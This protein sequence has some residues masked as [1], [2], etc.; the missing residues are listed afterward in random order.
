VKGMFHL[1]REDQAVVLQSAQARG[2]TYPF[3]LDI[4]E[5]RSGV[6][7]PISHKTESC[8]PQRPTTSP[9]H[10][11]PTESIEVEYKSQQCE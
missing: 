3:P 10:L 6:S 4:R 9:E 2:V 7:S 1:F 8:V 5:G 11:V